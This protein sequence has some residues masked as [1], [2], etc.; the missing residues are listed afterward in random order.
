MVLVTG[1]D[2]RQRAGCLVGFWTQCSLEPPRLVVCISKVN[3]THQVICGA[4]RLAVHFL[5][6]TDR[7]LAVLFGQASGDQVD[8]FARCRWAPGP[9]GAPVLQ[10]CA[11]WVVASVLGRMDLGDHT[12]VLGHPEEGSAGPWSGQLGFQATSGIFPGHPVG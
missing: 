10:D 5:A 8:K 12:G 6:R 3:Q 4:S 9:G 11:R 1:Y 2:G 7:E